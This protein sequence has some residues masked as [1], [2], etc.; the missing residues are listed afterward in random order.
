M[1]SKFIC[2]VDDTKRE[3]PK[4]KLEAAEVTQFPS[5]VVLKHHCQENIRGEHWAYLARFL[6]HYSLS[7]V[8]HSNKMQPKSLSLSPSPL[9]MYSTEYKMC[10]D[11][12]AGCCM[13]L[14]ALFVFFFCAVLTFSVTAALFVRVER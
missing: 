13:V 6:K 4:L 9:R 7:C 11:G 1:K 12:P 14:P 10:S 5:R 2:F 8:T 3:T